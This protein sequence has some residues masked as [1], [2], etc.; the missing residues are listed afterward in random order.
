M[1]AAVANANAVFFMSEASLFSELQIDN[2][3]IVSPRPPLAA[4]FREI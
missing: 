3:A 1:V 2:P 4:G